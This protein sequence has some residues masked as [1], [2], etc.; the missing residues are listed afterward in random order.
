MQ[1]GESCGNMKPADPEENQD[2]KEADEL[3][4]KAERESLHRMRIERMRAFKSSIDI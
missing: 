4:E 1:N 2:D 3:A